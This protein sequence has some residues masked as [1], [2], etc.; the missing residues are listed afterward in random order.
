MHGA[1]RTRAEGKTRRHLSPRLRVLGLDAMG[2]SRDSTDMGSPRKRK[3]TGQRR[4]TLDDVAKAAG[5]SPGAA[6]AALRGEGAPIKVSEETRARVRRVAQEL[7]YRPH[8]A[9]RAMAGQAFKALGVLA[10]GYV[11][12]SYFT[13]VL[14]GLSLEAE[15]LGYHIVLAM[16]S[17]RR[18]LL[19]A[20][21]F[22]SQLID[23]LIVPAESDESL[24]AAVAALNLPHVWL[25]A[26]VEEE[27]NCINPDE[28]QGME[29]LVGHLHELGHRRIAYIRHDD[30]DSGDYHT[31]ETRRLAFLASLRRRGLEPL[32]KNDVIEPVDELVDYFLNLAE[33]P[34]AIAVYS[35]AI[36]ALVTGAL[37]N[38]G[39]RVPEDMSVTGYEG[40]VWH[41]YAHPNLTTV[42]APVLEMGA[43][44]VRMLIEGIETNQPV[45]SIKLPHT[46]EVHASTGP[47]AKPR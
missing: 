27:L 30:P 15:R 12:G 4:V 29:L 39:V 25:N 8:A 37:L 20:P 6:S 35:D 34:T 47:V 17:S 28:E 42:K 10:A 11:Y 1:R 3:R 44:A 19:Q 9:A 36:G 32:P 43:A 38:R 41:Q 18:D 31:V 5:V 23:G 14:R 2:P 26:G 21:V 13:H 46:L 7:N 33:P 24:R 40:V 22:T 45:R 16:E